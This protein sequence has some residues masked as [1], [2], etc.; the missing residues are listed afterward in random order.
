VPSLLDAR[1]TYSAPSDR[2]SGVICDQ[3]IALNDLY[4]MAKPPGRAPAGAVYKYVAF[5][6][7]WRHRDA[8]KPERRRVV[9]Q[10]DPVQCAEGSPAASARAAA[11]IR[12]SI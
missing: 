7:A 8:S 1:R 9:A 5:K 6:T 12:D 4:N 11:V 10:G 2:T 3:T